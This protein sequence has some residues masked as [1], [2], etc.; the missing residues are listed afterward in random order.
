MA[1]TAPAT[2]EIDNALTPKSL[3]FAPATVNIQCLA[4]ESTGLKGD[5][6][7]RTQYLD[8][9]ELRVQSDI[10]DLSHLAVEGGAVGIALRAVRG[11][12]GQFTDA[13]QD[14]SSIDE[15]ALRSMKE[16]EKVMRI[17]L[18]HQ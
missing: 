13:L 3:L 6:L 15:S 10:V 17:K 7:C 8:A 11:L 14:I 5:R 4:R 9:V 16:D 12:K 18:R 2:L 1:A